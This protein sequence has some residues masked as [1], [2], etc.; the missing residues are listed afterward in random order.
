MKTSGT[1]SGTRRGAGKKDASGGDWEQQV[2]YPVPQERNAEASSPPPQGNSLEERI[3]FKA[4]LR[5]KERGFAGG[6]EVADWL[7]AEREVNAEERERN[8]GESR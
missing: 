5:A 4:W 3:R 2:D 7:E 1:R 8:G 6:D